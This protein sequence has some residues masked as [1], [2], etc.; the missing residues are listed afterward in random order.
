MM[1]QTNNCYYAIRFA[2]LLNTSATQLA[3]PATST[4]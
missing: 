3:V 4:T 1:G 2:Q